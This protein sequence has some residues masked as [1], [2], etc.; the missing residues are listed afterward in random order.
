MARGRAGLQRLV[1]AAAMQPTVAVDSGL[2][3]VNTLGGPASPAPMQFKFTSNGYGS[4]SLAF[5]P[6]G[7]S[8]GVPRPLLL[9]TDAG[10]HAVHLVDV[11][12]GSH[13]GYLA[14]PG[15]IASPRG[16]AASGSGTS[17][18]VAV[19]AWKNVL[20]DRGVVRV[21][22]G[23]GDAEWEVVQ[24][25]GGGVVGDPGAADGQLRWPFGLRFTRG[26]EAICV[27]DNGKNRASVFRVSGGGL[28]RHMDR[29]LR[30]PFDVEEVEGGWLV[31]CWGSNSV[32]FVGDSDASGGPGG[33]PSLGK[34]DGGRGAGSGEISRPSTLAVVPGLGLV[35]R[36]WCR[37]GRLQVFA[38][39]D[40]VA[41]ASMS[42]SRVAW[43][44]TVARA[45]S[46][47]HAILGVPSVPS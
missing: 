20:S 12:G 42:A 25:I 36:E 16:V 3:L 15:S 17:P 37:G 40:T 45:V 7:S 14:P 18:L 33:R 21:Y 19:S 31:L 26:G 10:H 27:A 35:V 47:H 8:S 9:V 23:S 46:R 34:A 11:V 30:S 39:P 1:P 6:P 29:E 2:T 32:V 22:R 13:A 24:V 38:A 5:T 43:M 28:E 44:G 4:G 41:M